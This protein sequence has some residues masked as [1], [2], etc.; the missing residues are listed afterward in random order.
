MNE[1]LIRSILAYTDL[2][3]Y[4]STSST[5]TRTMSPSPT[6][7]IVPVM[8]PVK[9]SSNLLIISLSVGSFSALLVFIIIFQCLYYRRKPPVL[10]RIESTISLT[11]ILVSQPTPIRLEEEIMND[12]CDLSPAIIENP[13][14][15][16]NVAI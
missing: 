3:A 1:T 5:L 14:H 9:D 8:S 4:R 11:P 2:I 12:P 6:L 15:H 10:S 16:K 7:S 13:M